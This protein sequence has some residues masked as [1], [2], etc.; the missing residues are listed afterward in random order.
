MA[1]RKLLLRASNIIIT[2]I[3]PL[4][5][6]IIHNI[7]AGKIMGIDVLDHVI[8]TKNKVFSF[9]EKKLKI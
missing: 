3:H 4:S 1:S 8:I 2:N 7:E 6:T 5:S 9:K